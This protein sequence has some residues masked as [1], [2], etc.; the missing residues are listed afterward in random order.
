MREKKDIRGKERRENESG[1]KSKW[2]SKEILKSKNAR[3][4][5]SARAVMNAAKRRS[6][7]CL[8]EPKPLRKDWK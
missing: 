1:G 7:K 6:L 3:N 2:S 8:K 5:S 4:S